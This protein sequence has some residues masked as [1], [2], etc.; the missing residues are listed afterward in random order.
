MRDAVV[1]TLLCASVLAGEMSHAGEAEAR[2]RSL[3]RAL[4][5]SQCARRGAREVKKTLDLLARREYADPAD[6][7]RQRRI[8][9]ELRGEVTPESYAARMAPL[10]AGEFT[11]QEA[12]KLA[13]LLED[14]LVKRWYS[15]VDKLR[16]RLTQQQELWREEL[17]TEYLNRF[18]EYE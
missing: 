12:E 17:S 11:T 3:T 13:D 8:L 1:L 2:S 14:P 15:A 10:F 18:I 16:P 6:Q 4:V 7:R 5:A 9:D